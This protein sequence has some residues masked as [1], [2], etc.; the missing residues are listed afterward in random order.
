MIT[1]YP[2]K[3]IKFSS[4]KIAVK[5]MKRNIRIQIMI[6]GD[7]IN[8]KNLK[9]LCQV[10]CPTMTYEI[11]TPAGPKKRTWSGPPETYNKLL[12]DNR[13]VFSKSGL[14]QYKQFLVR[15]RVGY[16]RLGGNYL[17]H[18]TKMLCEN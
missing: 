6:P 14:P 4:K 18:T 3:N 13:I 10:R 7:P 2:F 11:E 1:F 15:L 9:E 5:L 16:L 12:D 17:G 8:F